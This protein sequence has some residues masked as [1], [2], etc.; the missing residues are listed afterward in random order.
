MHGIEE[1]SVGV[2]DGNFF[3]DGGGGWKEARFFPRE[4]NDD[5]EEVEGGTVFGRSPAQAE[6][7][8]GKSD[9]G[10]IAEDLFSFGAV[11]GV[12]RQLFVPDSGAAPF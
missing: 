5:R 3:G 1:R 7:E 8:V 2:A 10:G 12:S 9:F 6:A 11:A 4:G